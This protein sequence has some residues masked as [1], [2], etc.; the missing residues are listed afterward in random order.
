MQLPL[1][2]T[3]RH[4]EASE[5]VENNI[6]DHAGE[7]EQFYDQ[8]MSCRVVV[9]ES[10]KHHHQGKL[11]QVHIDVTVPGKELVAGREPG[12]H[13]AHEDIYVAIRDAFD[14]M[15]RQL[16]DHARKQRGKVKSHEVPPHGKVSELAPD[17][18]YGRILTA[19]GRDIYFHRNSL[20]NSNFD[21]LE[22]GMEVRFDEE[23]GDL[24]PQASSVNVI[25]KH[26]IV[27]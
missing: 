4:I 14:A 26:H 5:A 22:I 15:Q 24:G 1:Q 20:L 17:E 12:Q 7:L 11:F 13:H 18:N 3:F 6:R 21:D 10:H 23:P 9:D 8:I 27:G 16:E 2:I 25:G 19:D